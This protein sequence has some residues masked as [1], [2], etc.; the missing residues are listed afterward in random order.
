MSA[1][2][3]RIHWPAAGGVAQLRGNCAAPAAA[4]DADAHSAESETATAVSSPPVGSA[5][6]A[7][8]GADSH[9]DGSVEA[10]VVVTPPSLAP[11]LSDRQLHSPPLIV[12]PIGGLI[13]PTSDEA[14][15]LLDL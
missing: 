1:A 2:L 8:A 13:S 11:R 14:S 10:L 6:A 7:A 15:D 12:S 5:T 9:P 4:L 3:G